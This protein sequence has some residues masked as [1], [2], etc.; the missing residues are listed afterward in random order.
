MAADVSTGGEDSAIVAAAKAG[1]AFLSHCVAAVAALPGA[2]TGVGL[3]ALWT[4]A[5]SAARRQKRCH[6]H[7]R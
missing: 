3:V 4:V 1:L 5:A 7:P 6:P 2:A